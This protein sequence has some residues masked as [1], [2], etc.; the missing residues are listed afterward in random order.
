MGKN[1]AIK[2][3]GKN[4][5]NLVVHKILAKY[6]NKPEAIEH[7]KHEIIAYRENIE[8]IAEKFNWNNEDIEEIRLVAIDG[9]EKEMN[10]DYPDVK[11]PLEEAKK[12]VDE[13]IE[14]IV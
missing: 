12:L 2:S 14:E 5:G 4:I 11:F 3:L 9:F 10:K 8:E 6:T 7:L 1:R 13:T